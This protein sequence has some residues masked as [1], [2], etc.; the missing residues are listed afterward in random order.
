MEKNFLL[1]IGTEEL[2][3]DSLALLEERFVPDLTRR[4]TEA[5]FHCRGIELG[6]TPRRI[7]VFLKG[8]PARQDP[9]VTEWLGPSWN[10]AYDAS[11]KPTPAL[12][13]FLR[14][15]NLTERDV[16]K[17]ETPRGVYVA[18]LKRL[19][20]AALE[21]V[22]PTLIQKA[23]KEFPF[24]KRMRWDDTGFSFPRPV[25][26]IVALCGSQLVRF[27]LGRVRADRFTYGHRFLAP[28]R[29]RVATADLASFQKLLRRA[30]VLLDLEERKAM[31]RSALRRRTGAKEADEEL[32][33]VTAQLV[34]FPHVVL[35]EIHPEFLKL[36]H[37]VLSSAMKK[38]QRI[39]SVHRG[40]GLAPQ[41]AAVLNGRRREE[42]KIVRDYQE[43]LEARLRDAQFFY[44]EDT[45]E[46]LEAKVPRLKGIIFLGKLGNLH[47]KISRM[48]ELA[49]WMGKALKLA[50]SEVGHLRRASYLS[51]ADLLA[52]MVYEFPDLQGIMGREYAGAG[53]EPGEVAQALADPYLPR[54]LSQTHQ[55]LAREQTKLGSLLA[56]IDKID[57]LVGAFGIGLEPTGSQDPYALRRAGGGIVKI[58]RA[59]GY[60]F[61]IRDLA[62]ESAGLYGE[63]LTQKLQIILSGLE[64]FF[65]ERIVFE[66][67][68][69]PGSRE[70][71]ILTAVLET[72]WA[73]VGGVF[74]RYETLRKTYDKH[75]AA[76]RKAHKVIER[77]HNILKGVKEIRDEVR[78]DL[79]REPLEKELYEIVE[80]K[81]P[82]LE[83]LASEEKFDSMTALYGELFYDTLHHFF[84]KVLVNVADPELKQNRQALMKA[85]NH[86]YV[87][88]V[89]DLSFVGSLGD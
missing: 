35:G 64:R 89:A 42:A 49:E 38:H 17:K 77:T 2:P 83:K 21:A 46:P 73:D 80:E 60:R 29:L 19:P 71:E 84:D 28:R 31:I 23:L 67:G 79:L 48:V 61:D 68:A 6:L 54:N 34:E 4:L 51:K 16:V 7:V 9:Q 63:R 76:F 85:I 70:E 59:F 39:F 81:T 3:T 41:F 55:A 72:E 22:V 8:L 69:R 62:R 53:G 18:A 58:I 86:L 52:Q 27:S 56:I 45:K 66:T 57:T 13:G 82:E 44:A 12:A 37:E 24:P 26:W 25:R 20:G 15:K 36:P 50:A 87:S 10:S 75:Q 32:V 5:R 40:K 43:V 14:S 65:K 1:E 30:G 74:L 47:E 33:A 88:R 11:G 78:R